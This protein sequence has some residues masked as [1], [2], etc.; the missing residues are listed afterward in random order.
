MS[1]PEGIPLTTKP[2]VPLPGYQGGTVRKDCSLC[3]GPTV[4][5][6]EVQ[7]TDAG[8]I[9]PFG[10]V[11]FELRRT[12]EPYVSFSNDAILDGATSQ[13]GFLED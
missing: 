12:V 6:G 11:H 10:E 1:L 7:P 2:H 3:A 13:E 5:D 8:L 9:M 4:L